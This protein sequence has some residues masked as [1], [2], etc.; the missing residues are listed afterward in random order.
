MIYDHAMQQ[1]QPS[2]LMPEGVPIKTEEGETH[3]ETDANLFKS[4]D[5]PI[6]QKKSKLLVTQTAT[7]QLL[8]NTDEDCPCDHT[9]F[10][11]KLCK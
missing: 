1:R 4:E 2:F 3:S 11:V 5:V 7:S 9:W 6:Y 10:G 8:I